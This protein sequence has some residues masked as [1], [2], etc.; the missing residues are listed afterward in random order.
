MRAGRI[1]LLCQSS[2]AMTEQTENAQRA[3]EEPV[4]MN[5]A[6]PLRAVAGEIDLPGS[7]PT[8]TARVNARSCRRLCVVS[9]RNRSS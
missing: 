9:P 3:P 6:L 1:I 4:S 5:G 2:G 7:L 8:R